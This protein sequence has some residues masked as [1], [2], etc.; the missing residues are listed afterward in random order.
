[1]VLQKG[2]NTESYSKI[3]YQ[4]DKES[5]KKGKKEKTASP[6]KPELRSPRGKT[7]VTSPNSTPLLPRLLS[8]VY[9]NRVAWRGVD[10]FG[11]MGVFESLERVRI[12][13]GS[14]QIAMISLLMKHI[15]A[16]STD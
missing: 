4:R 2:V 11:G 1:M 7:L 16:E 14:I 3:S 10:G 6:K 12:S 5:K 15:F 13:C 8:W 9:G